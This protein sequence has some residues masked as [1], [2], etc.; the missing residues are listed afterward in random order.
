MIKY[1]GLSKPRNCRTVLLTAVIFALTASI[2]FCVPATAADKDQAVLHRAQ[3]NLRIAAKQFE[4]GLCKEAELTLVQV[5]GGF[6]K[7]SSVDQEKYTQLNEKVQGS[8][9]E[10]YNVLAAIKLSDDLAAKGEYS[11]ATEELVAIVNSGA[12]SKAERSFVAVNIENLKARINNTAPVVEA[13][14]ESAVEA[15]AVVEESVLEDVVDVIVEPVVEIAAQPA[16]VVSPDSSLSQERRIVLASIKLSNELAANGHFLQAAEELLLIVNSTALNK[17]ERSF[18]AVNIENFKAQMNKPALVSEAVEEAEI[19]EAVVEVIAESVEEVAVEDVVEPVVEIVAEAVVEVAVQAPV[20]EKTLEDSYINSINQKRDRQISYTKAIVTNAI[21]KA[22]SYLADTEFSL[23]KQSVAKASSVVNRNK[24]LLGDVLYGQYQDELTQLD[25]QIVKTE[26]GYLA[27]QEKS[28]REET[29]QLQG[30]IRRAVESQKAEAVKGYLEG[31]FAFQRQQRYVEALGQL[32]QVLALEPNHDEAL[33]LKMTLEDTVLWRKQIE[34]QNKSAEQELAILLRSQETSIPYD[35]EINFNDGWKEIS[36]RRKESA[37]VEQSPLDAATYEALDKIVNLS[38]LTEDTPLY[39]AL[40]QVIPNSVE[41]PLSIFVDWKTLSDVA[42][43]DKEDPI[44]VSGNGLASI[45]LNTGLESILS[46]QGDELAELGYVV[47]DGLITISLKEYLRP[48]LEL[49]IYDIRE[50]VSSQIGGGMGGGMGGGGGMYKMYQLMEN[51]YQI[52]EDSWDEDSQNNSG[53]GGSSSIGS[54]T[55]DFGDEIAKGTIKPF[56]QSTLIISQTTEIHKKIEDFLDKMRFLNDDQVSI[57]ARFIVVDENFLEDI[58]LDVTINRLKLGGG[59]TLGSEINQGSFLAT[60]PKG[61]SISS[62]LGG[63]SAYQDTSPVGAGGGPGIQF[64]F[65]FTGLDDLAVDFLVRAT[66]THANAKTLTAPKITVINGEQGSIN[67]TSET[68]YVGNI[69]LESN[70]SAVPGIGQVD[71]GQNFVNEIESI[72]TGI[73][74][75]VSPTI[76][77]DKKYVILSINTNLSDVSFGGLSGTARGYNS[78]GTEIKQSFS[79]PKSQTTSIN[80]RVTVPDMGTILLGGLTLT[81]ERQI[82]SGVPFFSKIPI[83]QRF[84]SNRSDV[85]DKQILLILV[86]PTIILKSEAEEDAIAALEH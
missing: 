23:A 28:A 14:E 39:E 24:L 6:D 16:V 30:D 5:K 52:N 35:G 54:S 64:Q 70:S 42:F 41:P 17:A 76:T 82:E 83:I 71:T 26:N 56:G 74:M 36:K 67:V 48:N 21:S 85:K 50:I 49:R 32:E 61:T 79:L 27:Q 47:K 15:V 7:L 69:S 46:A 78:A 1:L 44:G 72:T 65:G 38:E 19:S 51:I 62:T 60:E 11:Q 73:T 43:I 22:R 84:F 77:A 75:M 31:A 9:Q 57:E 33:R 40:E 20:E 68:N 34:Q 29:E 81:A 59:F 63:S 66:E 10:R 18:V 55:D 3:W 86:R 4:K 58:G 25:E 12:L 45:P 13:V 37:K 53:R 2:F 8:L 80:T